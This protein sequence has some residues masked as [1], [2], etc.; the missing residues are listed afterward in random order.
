MAGAASGQHVALEIRGDIEREGVEPGIH[1]GIHLGRRDQ[2]RRQ[3]VGR[4]EGVDDAR[5]ERRPVLVDD[6]DGRL[7]QGLR[8]RR[9]GGV[10]RERE[11]VD[12]Q[13]QHHRIAQQA[14]QFL[15]AEMEDVGGA[16]GQRSCFLSRTA[17]R[18]MSTGTA[19]SSGINEAWRSAKPS[20]LEKV[21]REM[22]R[23]W[24]VG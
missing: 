24:V 16:H 23:K 12:D 10:D 3:E 15:D 9:G 1:P 17:P 6:G 8:H 11:G 2:C 14:A 22:V 18:P 21:P 4:I 5:G 19:S 13:H 20:A 7:V